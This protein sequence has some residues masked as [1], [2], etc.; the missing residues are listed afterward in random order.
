MARVMEIVGSPGTSDQR[1]RRA[2]VGRPCAE[3][4][5]IQG[6]SGGAS[7]AP[8]RSCHLSIDLSPRCNK[9]TKLLSSRAVT[10]SGIPLPR[11][12]RYSP[13]HTL[14]YTR[15]A[16]GYTAVAIALYIFY[17]DYIL[18]QS[19]D[20]TKLLTTYAVVVYFLLNGAF[21]AW[22]WFVERG[23]VF[24]G[25]RGSETLQ[26]RSHAPHRKYEPTYRVTTNWTSAAG[27]AESKEVSVPFTGFFTADGYFA[28]AEFEA[29][30]RKELPVIAQ[31][32]TKKTS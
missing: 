29:W 6:P 19:F 21:T 3:I 1:E 8:E 7:L 23:L 15:L 12:Q 14:I 13:V 5:K 24:H 31:G 22:L 11:P 4:P 17:L 10:P 16:L 26:I 20:D 30:L 32:E 2:V 25:Q 27:K 28:P 18:K 9:S